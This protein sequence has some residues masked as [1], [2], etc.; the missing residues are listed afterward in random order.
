MLSSFIKKLYCTVLLH[1]YNIAAIHAM[2]YLNVNKWKE[3]CRHD[4]GACYKRT[5]YEYQRE[6]IQRPPLG[7]LV[8]TSYSQLKMAIM[9]HQLP[10]TGGSIRLLDVSINQQE[11]L[12]SCGV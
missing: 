12:S 6:D 2:K 11:D 1:P 4:G 9:N 10:E 8:A 5:L 3:I 7:D